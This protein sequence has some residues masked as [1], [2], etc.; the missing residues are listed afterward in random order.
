M[1]T[2]ISFITGVFLL[3]TGLGYSQVSV[4]VN[5]P[6][7][8]MWGPVGYTQVRYYYL[9]DVEAYYDV[10]TSMFIY[11]GGGAWI[12]RAYLPAQYRN[13]DL[14]DGYKVVMPGYHGKTPYIHHKEYKSK[15]R[16]GYRGKYQKTVG[17]RPGSGH[18][19][20]KKYQ[21]ETHSKKG[22]GGSYGKPTGHGNDKGNTHSKNYG[23]KR[24]QGNKNDQGN[25]KD[26]GGGNGKRK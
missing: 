21:G 18:S 25:K 10:S 1:K 24:D 12:H 15:Y 22:D 3:I 13:Y 26:H 17:N 23:N 6:A 4:S 2:I 9:P 19:G 14:Y 8:P 16:K 11:Y 5:L 20:A 7:P